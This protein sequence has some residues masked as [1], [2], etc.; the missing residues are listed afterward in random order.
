[1]SAAQQIGAMPVV[2]IEDVLAVE[3]N[4][5]CS[6]APRNHRKV[7]PITP[8][9]KTRSR[10]IALNCEKKSPRKF[11]R[12]FLLRVGGGQARDAEAQ[13]QSDQ[14]QRDEDDAG[15]NLPFAEQVRKRAGEN[16]SP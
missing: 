2:Q 13:G 1:M 6:N 4:T 3:K 16:L 9:N 10:R 12:N 8:R 14:R 11:A 5:N 15:I 7:F